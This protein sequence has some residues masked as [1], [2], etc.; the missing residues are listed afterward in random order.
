MC[1]EGSEEGRYC[2]ALIALDCRLIDWRGGGAPGWLPCFVHPSA[3][4]GKGS[5]ESTLEVGD[6]TRVPL[7]SESGAW[8]RL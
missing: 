4:D 5:R 2:G 6:D 1:D 8:A 7:V 3:M